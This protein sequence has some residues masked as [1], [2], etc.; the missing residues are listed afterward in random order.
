MIEDAL[1]KAG[2]DVTFITVK[3]GGHSFGP[4]TDPSPMKV[5][6]MV[7]DFFDKQLKK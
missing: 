1:K 3:N 2:V 7:L 6:E 4:D 5:R